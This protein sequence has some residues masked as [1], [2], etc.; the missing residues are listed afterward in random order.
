MK[1]DLTSLLEDFNQRGGNLDSYEES[2]HL[3]G[4]LMQAGLPP[5]ANRSAMVDMA[6]TLRTHPNMV[7]GD[8]AQFTINVSRA[9]AAIASAV[10]IPIFGSMH[11]A[12][13]YVDRINP[14]SGGS[15]TVTGGV[16]V[17]GFN[18]VVRV[19]HVN[20]ANTDITTISC[21]EVPYPSFLSANNQDLFLISNIRYSLNDPT[22]LS[23]F[24]QTFEMR[25]KSLFG[26]GAANPLSPVSFKTPEQFQA[27]IIDIPVNIPVD[28]ETYLVVGVAALVISFSLAV[29]VQRFSKHDKV[30]LKP[31]SQVK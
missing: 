17:A 28:K 7:N 29:F 18:N 27:G 21:N 11:F 12:S 31:L 3:N 2:A 8:K 16:N 26:A 15:F 9:T 10:E 14:T 19:T 24:A 4:L 30:S 23:Q 22:Q 1:R 13:G 5:I 25:Q 20:G 6:S